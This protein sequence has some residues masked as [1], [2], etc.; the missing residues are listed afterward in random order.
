M[1]ENDQK[2]MQVAMD[3]ARE[4]LRRNEVPIGAVVVCNDTIIGRGYN[5][6]ENLQDVTAHAEII[7]IT[8]AANYLGSKYLKECTLYVTLEPCTMCAGALR[9][10]Q[11]SRI[12]YAAPDSKRGYTTTAP[13][14][15][16]PKTVVENGVLAEEAT[17]MIQSFFRSKRKRG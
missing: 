1:S 7:A 8:A 10:A 4:A 3:E 11:I 6:T 2:Y 5:L 12:V 14:A 16:H 9:W 15:L 17:E 13:T